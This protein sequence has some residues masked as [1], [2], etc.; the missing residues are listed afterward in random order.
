MSSHAEQRFQRIKQRAWFC[1]VVFPRTF[2]VVQLVTGI[3]IIREDASRGN[4]SYSATRRY[5]NLGTSSARE[6]NARYVIIAF[7]TLLHAKKN[8]CRYQTES[9][10]KT[11]VGVKITNAIPIRKLYSVIL[12]THRESIKYQ[13]VYWER[14]KEREK[15]VFVVHAKTF[16]IDDFKVHGWTLHNA[17]SSNVQRTHNETSRSQTLCVSIR[18]VI[19]LS[20]SYVRLQRNGGFNNR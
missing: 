2:L 4:F 11:L 7:A 17:R 16:Y 14:K 3:E 8:T 20:N 9:W 12:T 13:I 6:I 19:V 15:F 10:F 5:R 18:I 1:F